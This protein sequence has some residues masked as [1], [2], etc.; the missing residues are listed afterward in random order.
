M[1][2]PIYLDSLWGRTKTFLSTLSDSLIQGSW[3]SSVDPA[4]E[5]LQKPLNFCLPNHWMEPSDYIILT[6]ACCC[7]LLAVTMNFAL[8]FLVPIS[9]IVVFPLYCLQSTV[10]DGIYSS[11]VSAVSTISKHILLMQ[12]V[13]KDEKS[14]K[15]LHSYLE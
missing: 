12:W 1:K 8:H 4:F 13:H 7:T 5:D 9:H 11:N 2:W 15:W 10:F 14:R 3:V 6:F